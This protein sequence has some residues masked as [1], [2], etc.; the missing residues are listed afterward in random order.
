MKH[1]LSQKKRIFFSCSLFNKT[2]RAEHKGVYVFSDVFVVLLLE[3]LPATI[4]YFA[5]PFV[6]LSTAVVITE[7]T[8]VIII[9]AAIAVTAVDQ[10]MLR[11][12]LLRKEGLKL[13]LM[14]KFT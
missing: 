8:V 9:V 2:S 5:C 10:I 11:I 14:K 12:T 6:A 13:V 7:V 3:K 1:K 4:L